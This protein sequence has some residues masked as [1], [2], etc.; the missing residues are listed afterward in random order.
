MND[1]Q[2]NIVIV[3]VIILIGFLGARSSVTRQQEIETDK[4]ESY[5][6]GYEDGLEHGILDERYCNMTILS[7]Y[8]GMAMAENKNAYSKLPTDLNDCYLDGFN[9]SKEFTSV[10]SDEIPALHESEFYNGFTNAYHAVTGNQEFSDKMDSF[11]K[12]CFNGFIT[13]NDLHCYE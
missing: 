10:W 4:E 12:G 13:V 7:Y 5:D 8:L 2:K 9:H 6:D 1:L 11:M 3:I